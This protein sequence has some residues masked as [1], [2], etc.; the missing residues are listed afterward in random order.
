MRK[1][2][3]GNSLLLDIPSGHPSRCKGAPNLIPKKKSSAAVAVNEVTFDT[4]IFA[5]TWGNS[6]NEQYGIDLWRVR[7]VDHVMTT[8]KKCT[9]LSFQ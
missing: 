1:Y 4:Y 9:L 6:F 7:I 2:S 8:G 5:G 3:H